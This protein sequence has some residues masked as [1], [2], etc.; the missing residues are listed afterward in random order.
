MRRRGID[1]FCIWVV[2][3]AK[4][5]AQAFPIDRDRAYARLGCMQGAIGA[6]IS[7]VLDP[8]RIARRKQ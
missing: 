4:R 8:R 5:H 7:G 1:Q 6:A 2:L 3:R